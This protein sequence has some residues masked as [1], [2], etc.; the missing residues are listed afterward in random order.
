MFQLEHLEVLDNDSVRITA[1]LNEDFLK[2]HSL[3]HDRSS[4][5]YLMIRA[6]D[7]VTNYE[8]VLMYA[9][10]AKYLL[11]NPHDDAALRFLLKDKRIDK[12]DKETITSIL[13]QENPKC[14]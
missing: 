11:D 6:G 4:M 3:T 14:S 8:Y 2:E 9:C 1:K 12:I 7:A 10:V 5:S 13:K